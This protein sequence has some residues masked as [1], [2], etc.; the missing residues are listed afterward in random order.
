MKRRR[1]LPCLDRRRERELELAPLVLAAVVGRDSHGERPQLPGVLEGALRVL[2]L[3]VRDER[4][5]AAP[6][7]PELAGVGPYGGAGHQGAA[8][9]PVPIMAS[10]LTSAASSFSARASVPAGRCG[11]T[12]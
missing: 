5:D 7:I 6:G 4:L 11:S 8:T 1:E 3:E 12:Q 10:R 2:D 9:T